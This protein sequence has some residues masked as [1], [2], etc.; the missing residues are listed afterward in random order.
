MARLLSSGPTSSITGKML[1]NRRAKSLDSIV[2]VDSEPPS[3][4]CPSPTPSSG[5]DSNKDSPIQIENI[6][7]SSIG[8][9]F[10]S[11]YIYVVYIE[12][13]FLFTRV[14]Q[15]FY[16]ANIRFIYHRSG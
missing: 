12:H 16:Q 11:H 7:G 13:T 4:R 9:Y 5:V 8:T 10:P 6:D 1:P 3:P 15:G 14:Q 2:I